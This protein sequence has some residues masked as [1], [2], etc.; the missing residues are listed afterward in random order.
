MLK[1]HFGNM[2]FDQAIENLSTNKTF[3]NSQ[4]WRN[5]SCTCAIFL[6]SYVCKHVIGI[7]IRLG[8]AEAPLEAKNVPLGQK[9]KR[10]RPSRAKPAL[11]RQ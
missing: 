8:L 9:R 2:N 11:I 5:S 7:A 4:N 1:G 3:I 6:K 10:G